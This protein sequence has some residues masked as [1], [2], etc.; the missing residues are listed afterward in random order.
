MKSWVI[1]KLD[2]ERSKYLFC[3]D[4]SMGRYIL[5]PIDFFV[6]IYFTKNIELRGKY[7]KLL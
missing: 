7:K 2:K 1:L 4:K 3:T 5:I 6:E